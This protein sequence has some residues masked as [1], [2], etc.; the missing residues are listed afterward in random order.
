[1]IDKT[2]LPRRI[3]SRLEKLCQSLFINIILLTGRLF[4]EATI[5]IPIG[6]VCLDTPNPLDTISSWP[7][8]DWS[9]MYYLQEV[10]D[11]KVQVT[12]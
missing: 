2:N 6:Q 7:H 11:A 4:L 10:F 12:Q 9:A 8:S 1:M 3:L 5:D